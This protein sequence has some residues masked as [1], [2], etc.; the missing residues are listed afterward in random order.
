MNFTEEWKSLWALTST[1]TPQSLL[2][3]KYSETPLGPLLFTQNPDT[4]TTTLLHSSSL[5]PRLPPPYPDLSLPR[6][7]QNYNSTPSSISSLL[8]PQLPDYSSHFHSFNSLQLLHVPNKNLIIAF[9][10]TG[11]NSDQVG[12]SLLAVKDGILSLNSKTENF[13]QL[14]KEGCVNR[15]R[16]TRLLV[17]PFN[18]FG[19]V[20]SINKLSRNNVIVVGFL[21]VCTHYSVYWYRVEISSFCGDSDFSVCLNYLGCADANTF[22]GN[23]VVSACWSPHLRQECLILLENGDILLFDVNCSNERKSKLIMPLVIGKNRVIKRITHISMTDKV[24]LEKEEDD[25]EGEGWF[26]VEFSYHHRIFIASHRKGVFLVDLRY[27]RECNVSCLMKLETVFVVKNDGFMA[28]SMAGSSGFYFTVSTKCS[29]F[30]CDV[31]KPL[32]PMLRWTHGLENPCYMTVFRLSDLRANAE[33]DKCKWA[34]ESGYC[35]LLGSFWDSDFS[36]FCYGPDDNENGS[37][38]S[39]IS[40]FCNTHYCWGPPS[41]LSLSDPDCNCGSCLVREEFSKMSLPVWIDWRQKKDLVMGFA[42][43][44]SDL[45]AEVS[46]PSSF[47]GFTLLRLM[48]SGKLEAQQYIAAWELDNFSEVNHKRKRI[49]SEEENLLYDRDELEYDGIKKFQHMKFDFLNAFLNDKLAQYIFKRK[50]VIDEED[51]EEIHQVKSEPNFHQEICQKMKAFGL[52]KLRSSMTVSDVLKD[53]NLPT[54]LHEVALRCT[55][56]GLPTNMLKLGFSTYSDLQNDIENDYEPLEFLV[57]PDQLQVPPFP[58]R[59]PSSRS[60]KWSSKVQPY[61]TL[62]GPVVP[63]HFLTILHKL[64]M[65]ERK[66]ERD[67]YIEETEEFSVRSQFKLECDK[68]TEVVEENVFGSDTKTTQDDNENDFVSLADD[69]DNMSSYGTQNFKLSFHKPLAFSENLSG[70]ENDVFSRHVFRRNQDT[71]FDVSVGMVG[72]ELFDV[73]CPIELKFDNSTTEFGPKELEMYQML[74]KQDLLFQTSFKNFASGTNKCYKFD[75]NT[76]ISSRNKSST[77]IVTL[78]QRENHLKLNNFHLIKF[79]TYKFKLFKS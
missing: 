77:L 62:I 50:I 32:M 79:I 76:V 6:F 66:A 61:D 24:S 55:W 74:K 72:Q 68:V 49:D 5:A 57:I 18:D 53:I 15:Q 69:T 29:L 67:P 56:A 51:A 63:P 33:D 38:S 64:D 43:L 2:S 21:M 65:E 58:F 31:R 45:F 13:F 73:G 12:F 11:E 36:L 54:S 44:D 17:N 35:I 26:G 27:N 47:G 20:G 70:S 39:E 37:V 71:A 40:K 19:N 7:L 30:L 23:S 60:N 16:I 10:P 78:T 14:A 8:G 52:P 22:K 28:L 3:G 41:E 59:K 9:F 25:V 42:T 4:P 48:S 75:K 1:F 46:T 34:S